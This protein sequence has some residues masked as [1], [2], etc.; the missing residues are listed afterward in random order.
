MGVPR[1]VAH[2]PPAQIEKQLPLVRDGA[3]NRYITSPGNSLAQ[4]TDTR[5]L[6]W[7]FRVEDSREVNAFAVPGGWIYVNRGLIER[8]R[9]MSQVAGVL[10]HEIGHVTRRHSVQQMQ[11]AQGANVGVTLLCTLTGVC[12][13]GTGRA[14]VGVGGGA[15]FAKF[16]RNDE[17]EADAEAVRTTVAAGIDPRGIPEMFHIL[18]SERQRNPTSLEAFF[19]THPLAEDRIQE[20]QA[21]IVA[22]PAGRLRG[23]S[24]DTREFQSFRSR[25]QSLPP[26]PA[27]RPQSAP[28]APAARGVSFAAWDHESLAA[29]FRGA[30]DGNPGFIARAPGRV[31][32][33][34]EHVDYCGLP[35][36]PMALERAVTIAARPRPDAAARF[37]NL[38]P[39]F[40]D[41]RF[42]VSAA[43]NPQAPGDWGNYLQAAAQ[44]LVTR[45]GALHGIDAVVGSDL[46]VAA[47]L[48]SSSALVVA[49]A[50]ALLA[51]N[52]IDYDPP[53][54]M[55]LLAAGE[56]YV[57]TASGGMDQAISLGARAGFAARIEFHPV[58]LTH[59]AVPDDWRFLV[60]WSRKHAE[61]SG[62]ARQHYNART[63]ETAAAREQV[64]RR[65]GLGAISSYAVLLETRSAEELLEAGE[66][67]DPMLRRRYR[68]VVSEGARVRD[69]V[70]AMERGDLAT[71]GTLMDASHASLAADY[72]VSSPEL[73]RLVEAARGAGAAG[74]RLTGAGF[75]GSV[76]ALAPADRAPA[77]LRGIRERFY[78]GAPAAAV[79]QWLFVAKPSAGAH[80]VAS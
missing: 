62:T 67:L 36:L 73:D 66:A 80:I 21:Q 8:A 2:L 10:G 31:N 14:A 23:L 3:V 20:T 11:Q 65:L 25:V 55:E 19:S 70:A 9:T 78:A 54:L 58:R 26:P 68:H 13:S 24:R 1:E 33:I 32:L 42:R 76:V 38:A 71:F 50:V 6:R 75:G 77:V 79:E 74:A 51:A 44:A 15:L 41:R 35:V 72:E 48:S 30:Y 29:R 4:V 59:V 16:S 22:L 60:A 5:G 39:S 52:E 56:K 17:R 47:G 12:E 7:Q 45:Y 53:E 37:I 61:K 40:P 28:P 27:P 43:I 18:L 63:E 57:G 46:P 49:V 34:G 69:A 64:A